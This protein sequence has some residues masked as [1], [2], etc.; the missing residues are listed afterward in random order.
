MKR[1][2]FLVFIFSKFGILQA[3]DDLVI[4]Y[5]QSDRERMVKLELQFDEF[6]KSTDDNFALIREDL[7]FQI[8]YIDK[9]NDHLQT[10]IYFVIGIIVSLAGGILAYFANQPKS[11]TSELKKKDFVSLQNT[12]KKLEQKLDDLAAQQSKQSKM[13]K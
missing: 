6:K 3:K 7:R 8:Q 10:L 9:Q 5:R 2:I 13:A 12:V 1:I 4:P 11:E